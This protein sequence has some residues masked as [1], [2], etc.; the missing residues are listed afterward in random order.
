M[1]AW[2]S[3]ATELHHWAQKQLSQPDD[4][5]DLLQEVFFKALLQKERFCSIHNARA[6]LFRVSRNTLIDRYKLRRENIEL[7]DN[8][9]VTEELT[10]SVDGLTQCLPRVLSE[11]STADREAITLCDLEHRTQQQFARHK[12]ISLAAAKSRVQRARQRLRKRLEIGCQIRHDETGNICC[13][14]PRPPL[15]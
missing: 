9:S 3:H 15:D 4:A 13:F 11:L 7:P 14:V 8:L 6:W 5:D 1:K 12:G 2:Y 10:D